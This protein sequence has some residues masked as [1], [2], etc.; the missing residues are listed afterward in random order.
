MADIL[1]SGALYEGNYV[2][3]GEGMSVSVAPDA[4][5]VWTMESLESP[6]DS[7]ELQGV[8]F[9]AGTVAAGDCATCARGI[10]VA[11][12]G[13][14]RLLPHEGGVCPIQCTVDEEARSFSEIKAGY[15]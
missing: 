7:L 11:V 6:G 3:V 9:D 15:R 12:D 10:L 4:E 1:A 8:W 13:G 2:E 5:G 14:F